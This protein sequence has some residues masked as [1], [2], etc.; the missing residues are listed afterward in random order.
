MGYLN[1]NEDIIQWVQASPQL[2]ESR[3]LERAAKT[4]EMWQGRSNALQLKLLEHGNAGKGHVVAQLVIG[5]RAHSPQEAVPRVCRDP[6]PI[7]LESRIGMRHTL[8]R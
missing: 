2:Q 4:L 6:A 5:E 1:I 7:Q 3:A 8:K